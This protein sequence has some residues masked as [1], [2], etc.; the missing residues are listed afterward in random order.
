MK[1]EK[2][3]YMESNGILKVAGISA[4][5]C[6]NCLRKAYLAM[7]LSE[8]ESVEYELAHQ[9]AVNK[10][11]TAEDFSL[12]YRLNDKIRSVF[13]TWLNSQIP[14]EDKI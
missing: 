2:C 12:L 1:C 3:R 11:A 5:L 9:S 6:N 13:M 4:V 8:S 14:E 10:T 7:M